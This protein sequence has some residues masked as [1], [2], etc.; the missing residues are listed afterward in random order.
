MGR[1]QKR[2]ELKKNKANN[3]YHGNA[4]T[5]TDMNN[6][7]TVLK[8]I[9]TVM[10]VLIVIYY[11]VAI[12]VTKEIDF[13]EKNT[14]SSDNTTTSTDSSSVSNKILASNT[15]SQTDQVYYVYFYDFDNEDEDVGNAIDLISDDKVYRVDTK[16]GLNSKYVT[17]DSGNKDV[18]DINSLKVINPTIIKIDND[19]VVEYH[20]GASDILSY[21][22]K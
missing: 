21:L 11:A 1:E 7:T 16:S 14:S 9:F 5:N 4:N 19:K 15:F 3:S 12:L 18:S 10:V 8:V 17:S 6:L 2:K 13:S 20:E 22:N